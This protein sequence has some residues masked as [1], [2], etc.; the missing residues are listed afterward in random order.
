[1]FSLREYAEEQAAIKKAE[2]D[3]TQKR[4][5][6]NARAETIKELLKITPEEHRED[7]KA[8]VVENADGSITVDGATFTYCYP[9]FRVT[10]FC[11]VCGA[12]W[13]GDASGIVDIYRIANDACYHCVAANTTVRIVNVQT[14]EEKL[15]ESL[16]EF[17]TDHTYQP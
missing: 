1:M 10:A 9:Y 3:E 2:Q 8:L 4:V 14:V 16:R 6:A 5:Y 15:L 12:M 13:Q 7:V 11:A 17:V